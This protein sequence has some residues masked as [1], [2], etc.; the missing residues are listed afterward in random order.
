MLTSWTRKQRWCDIFDNHLKE[1]FGVKVFK[2][3]NSEQLVKEV[4][5]I[6]KNLSNRNQDFYGSI[7]KKLHIN[8]ITP[9]QAQIVAFVCDNIEILWESDIIDKSYKQLNN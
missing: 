8:S 6:F 2:N 5:E 7:I 4:A 9:Q 1:I 3:Q